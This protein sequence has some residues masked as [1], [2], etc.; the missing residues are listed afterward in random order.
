MHLT[1]IPASE[2]KCTLSLELAS[3]SQADRALA[4]RTELVGETL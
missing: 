3:E 4:L 2:H 1:L